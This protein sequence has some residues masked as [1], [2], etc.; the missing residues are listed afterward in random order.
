MKTLH[1][2]L[3]DSPEAEAFL[4]TARTAPFVTTLLEEPPAPNPPELSLVKRGDK[5]VDP[6]ELFGIWRDQPR[7]LVEIRRGVWDRGKRLQFPLPDEPNGT[8]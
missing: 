6:T 1:L 8:L 7:S 3:D 4:Q 2:T 5:S